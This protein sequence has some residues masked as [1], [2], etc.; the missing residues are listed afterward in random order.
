MGNQMHITG[1]VAGC[2]GAALAT[3]LEIGGMSAW[4]ML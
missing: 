4:L 3:N 2:A 1:K